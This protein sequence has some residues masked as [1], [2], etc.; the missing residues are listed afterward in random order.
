MESSSA[1]VSNSYENAHALVDKGDPRVNG[2][3]LDDVRQAQED[4][5]RKK[6]MNELNANVDS[7]EKTTTAPKKAAKS[8]KAASPK[9]AVAK[10][11][12]AKKSAK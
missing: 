10:K 8:K 6:R 3:Y 9:K 2:P 12:V 5:Y 7:A 11:T 1:V 4:E